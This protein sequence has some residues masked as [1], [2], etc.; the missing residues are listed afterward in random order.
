M[1]RTGTG[2]EVMHLLLWN[3]LPGKVRMSALLERIWRIAESTKARY[4]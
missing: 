3:V 1:I 4:L 2:Y